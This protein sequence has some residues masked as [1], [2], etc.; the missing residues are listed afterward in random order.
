LQFIISDLVLSVNLRPEIIVT[1]GQLL[2]EPAF[3]PF[4]ENA[5]AIVMYNNTALAIVEATEPDFHCLHPV[6]IDFVVVEDC[7]PDVQVAHVATYL[8]LHHRIVLP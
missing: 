8:S 5:S 2:S 4:I 6:N 7:H 1:T 3:D